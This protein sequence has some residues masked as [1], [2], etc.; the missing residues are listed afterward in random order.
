MHNQKQL[1]E[2]A[3]ND[4]DGILRLAPSWVPRAFCTPGKRLKLHPNDYYAFG[5][6]RGGIDER[7]L[8]STVR[9][10]NGPQTQAD[11]GLSY[12]QATPAGER[13]L[14]RDAIEIAGRDILGDAVMR[15]HG[16]WTMFSKFFDNQE[17]LGF[18]MH[19][20]DRQATEIGRNGKPEAYYFPAQLNPHSGSFPYTFFGLHPQTTKAE[21]KRC[22]ADWD[23]G[24]NG[25]LFLSTAYKLQ[26]GTGWDVPAGVLHAPGSLLTYEPQQA[27]DV[28]SVFQSLVWDSVTPREALTKDIPKDPTNEIDYIVDLLDWDSNVDPHFYENHFTLSK[29]AEPI[30]DMHDSGYEEN[31][32]VY[33]SDRFSAKELTV[34][35]KRSVT[36]RDDA[37][38]GAVIVQGHG[39][40]GRLDVSSPTMIRFGQM[41]HDEVFVVSAAAARGVTIVNSS[42]SENL[43]M[44]KH[45]GPRTGQCHMR[46]VRGPLR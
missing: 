29:P 12:V 32:I 45:F 43:V 26:L 9:A 6:D 41:T 4:G 2:A 37:P 19:L 16:G 3:L 24:D 36:I 5:A 15:E 22:L 38:Y 31:W 17:P 13:V 21:V 42:D 18:H 27:S 44:L 46:L 30:A 33:R 20:N 23:R 40:I 10:D 1:V 25:I 11:E 7:W 35:P 34:F 14:L 28:S 8:A 39:T